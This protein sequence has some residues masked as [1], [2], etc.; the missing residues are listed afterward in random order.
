MR[1]MMD[2]HD[3]PSLMLQQWEFDPTQMWRRIRFDLLLDVWPRRGT[4]TT[5]G[6]VRTLRVGA[7]GAG[8]AVRARG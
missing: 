5:P 6:G 8:V 4:A 1:I 7:G 3:Y 2:K